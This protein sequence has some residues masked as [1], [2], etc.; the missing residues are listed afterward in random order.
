M[1]VWMVIVAVVFLALLFRH[2]HFFQDVQYVRDKI[3]AR[4][5]VLK[6]KQTNYSILDR[7]LEVVKA[8]PHKPFILFN[9]E[10][11]TYQDADELS[12][13]AAR[14]FLHNGLVKEGDTVALFLRNEPMFL[15][16]WLG[17]VKIGCNAAFLNY[18]I[19]S[20]SLFH[21]FSRSGAKTLVAAEELH[22]AVEELLPSLLEQQVTVFILADRCRT[23]NME[24]FKDK[25]SQASSKPLSNDL[26]SHL[27]L[28]SP[29]AYIYTS[30]TTGLPK[31]AIIS[32]AKLWTLACSMSMAG[33]TSQD[34]LFISLPLYHTTGF[35]GFISVIERGN[36]L[37]LRSKFSASQF[38]D[39]CRKYNVT[40]IMFIG[41]MMRYLCNTPKKPNDQSHK[42]RLAIG[43]GLRADVWRYFISR[44]GNVQIKEFYGAT[45]GNFSLL[46]Y[47]GKIGA[48]GRDTFLN[49]W[50][51]PY[52]V[53]KFD[54]E[55]G[56]PLRD[57]SGLC[58]EAAKGEPGLLVSEI[59]TRAPFAGYVRDLQQNEKKRLHDVFK[60]GDLYFNTGDLLCID[61]DNFI[62]FKDRVGD[63]FRWKGENVATTEVADIITLLDCIKEANVYGVEVPGQEGR[64]GMATVTLSETQRFDPADV[65]KHVVSFLPA[66]ARPC[67]LRIQSS[68]DVTSTFKH[69]KVKLAEEGFNPNQ[70]TDP[71]YFLDEKNKNYVQL[72]VDIFNSVTSGKIRI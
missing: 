10:T 58:I 50:V 9:G 41:E 40:V 25:M 39:D 6:Y 43:S 44:F 1:I 65:F 18:N 15:W 49:K 71:L 16:L 63:T 66:Y 70:I 5:R 20:K 67:F 37:A 56:T 59:S 61:E 68:L 26:R 23:A 55:K 19:R 11:F 17:L 62:Y 36:T 14:V 53:I 12:N 13:K 24:S 60:K 30:G 57:S 8:Q 52:A 47:T 69:M 38:W 42:V 64:A 54:A 4:R 31:A 3:Q 72:T 21:C 27:T 48:V 34:V 22:N 29:A 45:E 35:L 51:F 33:V 2:P 28:Q 46:N 7:F 32:H